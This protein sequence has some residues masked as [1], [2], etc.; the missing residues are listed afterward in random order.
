MRSYDAVI[1]GAGNAG[2]GAAA[3][4]VS[5]GLRPLVI[6]RHNLPGGCATSFVRGRFEFDASIHALLYDCPPLANPTFKQCWERIGLT[7]PM[8]PVPNG[9]LNMCI[10]KDGSVK[11]YVLDTGREEFISSVEKQI[12]GSREVMERFFNIGWELLNGSGVLASVMDNAG[13]SSAKDAAVKRFKHEYPDYE[14][15][16]SLSAQ[17]AFEKLG[18]SDELRELIGILWF[19][20]GVRLDRIPFMIYCGMF[21]TT[22]SYDCYFPRDC[23]HG[24]TAE[25]EKYIRENG[26]DMWFNTEVTEIDVKDGKVCAV[27][28]DHGDVIETN[29]V[30]SNAPPMAVYEKLIQ[31]K[32]AV[33]KKS[34]QRCRSKKNNFS[35][36]I[37][38]LGLDATAEKIGMRNHHQFINTTNDYFATYDAGFTLKK[39]F[40]MGGLCPNVTVKDFSPE[41]T[42]VLSI[43]VPIQADAFEGLGQ[44]E[45]FEVKEKLAADIVTEYE[46]IAGLDLHSHIEEIS[47]A[48]PATLSR[49][50]GMAGGALGYQ[51]TVDTHPIAAAIAESGMKEISGLS[52]VGQFA[53]GIGY[54]NNPAGFVHGD[55]I[56]A[57]LKGGR[58]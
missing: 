25:F 7:E 58:I 30:I 6:E 16:I 17:Q 24:Y 54:S 37:V 29:C 31:P 21:L 2:L 47:V 11:K 57:A 12:P 51:I 41:G 34:V 9:M 13:D 18:M 50:V 27:K 45:Y 38:Y 48:T 32:S 35:F 20:P 46:H 15:Y 40:C 8:Y 39:P 19:Y 43:A 53:S 22:V 26:G 52:F 4:L 28:T 49:Y 44:K 42:S 1:I 23:A 3:S 14:A 36:F 10:G 33:A 5:Q 56:G 55:N